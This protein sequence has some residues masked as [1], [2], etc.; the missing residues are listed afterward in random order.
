MKLNIN[1][2][3]FTDNTNELER[4]YFLLFQTKLSG[5]KITQ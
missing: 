4:F 3:I 5:L 1:G 2:K